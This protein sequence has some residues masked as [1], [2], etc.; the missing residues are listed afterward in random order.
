MQRYRA[1]AG[2]EAFILFSE[3]DGNG[4]SV[5]KLRQIIFCYLVF[6]GGIVSIA[7]GSFDHIDFNRLPKTAFET[8]L[9][10]L[11]RQMQDY[12]GSDAGRKTVIIGPSYAEDLGRVG[13]AFNLSLPALQTNEISYIV[14]HQCR[15]DKVLCVVTLLALAPGN[16]RVRN[17]VVWQPIRRMAILRAELKRASFIPMMTL[18]MSYEDKL[19]D[20]DLDTLV[21]ELGLSNL[22]PVELFM[23]QMQLKLLSPIDPEKIDLTFF[24]ELHAKH[25]DI[26]FV[27]HPS[28]PLKPLR[29]DIG[30][31]NSVFL[32]RTNLRQ[33]MA[34]SGLPI[35]DL[36]DV[37]TAD[38]FRDLFHLKNEGIRIVQQL[39]EKEL[40]A[41]TYYPSESDMAVV[42][43]HG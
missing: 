32:A 36:S 26:V 22:S 12:Q 25:P 18:A 10:R 17:V 23:L 21:D 27:M 11:D 7:L 41:E 2:I 43:P 15:D 31:I 20:R 4:L 8:T 9:L 13:P 19:P 33:A 16:D 40:F 3:K 6:L 5:K 39:I 37:L 28:L 14:T 30:H 24:R 29:N 42:S 34:E 38:C 35:V 1:G